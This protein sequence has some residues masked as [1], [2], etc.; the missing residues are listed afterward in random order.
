MLSMETTELDRLRQAY[1]TA[2]D[3]WV[4]MIRQEEDLATPDHS[5]VQMER[6]DTAGFREQDAMEKAK[7]AKEEYKSALREVNYSF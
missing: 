3:Q 7:A 2:V 1:K 6:W 5:M 4:A